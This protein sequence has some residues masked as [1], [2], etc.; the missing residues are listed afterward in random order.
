MINRREF[1]GKAAGM[2][3]AVKS[4]SGKTASGQTA[5]QAAS[6]RPVAASDKVT[7]G[8]IGPGSRGQALM[9]AFLRVP[10]VRFG[11]L[12]D[13]YEPRFAQARKITGGDT[14]AV[15]DYRKLVETPGL[16][17]II[18]STPLGLHT[19][20]VVAAVESGHHVYGE[21]SMAIDVAGCNRILETV[22][23]GGKYFQIGHQYH[24][25]PWYEQALRQINAGKI[26]KVLQIY[27][28]WHRNNNW[29]RPVPDPK[30]KELERLINWRLY[31]QYSGGLLAELGSHH[32]HFATQVFGELPESV[33]GTGGVDFWK[34]GR[35]TNDDTQTIFRYADGRTLFFSAL[36]TNRMEGAQIQVY[37]TGGTLV[38]TQ[39]D[40][41]SFYEPAM[42]SS[43]VPEGMVV[44]HGIV[45]SASFRA[46]TPYRGPGE[47]IKVPEGLAGNPDFLACQSF[48]D[49]IRNHRK[50][51]ADE[52][53]GWNSAIMVA[54]GNQAV[55]SNVPVRFADHLPKQAG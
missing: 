53:S 2:V 30:N 45:T 25:A 19:D 5:S 22:K 3:A 52:Q 47:P 29:R 16:D 26:G 41:M 13:V 35:E 33:V 10:G 23:R 9:R 39:A 14:P 36:T 38:I 32:F 1:F 37:G 15:N 8:I 20:H 43:A 6:A 4:L 17:A 24:Y 27:A 40:A 7:L 42:P 12:C 46:E 18:V 48:V 50:P 55:D 28:Y 49:S 44:E 11:A 34:D 21:K 54:L 51:S 31:R